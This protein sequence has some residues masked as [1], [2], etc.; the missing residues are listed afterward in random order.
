MDMY[1]IL[2]YLDDIR[3]AFISKSTLKI[4]LESN[5]AKNNI[6]HDIFYKIFKNYVVYLIILIMNNIY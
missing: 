6:Y 5:L 4:Y 1:N 2:S 3:F